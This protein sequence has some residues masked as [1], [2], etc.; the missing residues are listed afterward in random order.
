[1]QIFSQRP[2]SARPFEQALLALLSEGRTFVKTWFRGFLVAAIAFPALSAARAQDNGGCSNATLQGDY[3]FSVLTVATATGPNVVVGL[4]RFDGRGRFQQT[5]FPGNG[6]TD[7]GLTSF[8]TGQTGS[9]TINP[10]CTGFMT[11]DLGSAV[12]TVEN[13]LVI[14]NGGGSIHAVIAK[15]T[16]PGGTLVTPLQ[17]RIEFW[18]VGSGQT[19]ED[20]RRSHRLPGGAA[21]ARGDRRAALGAA[22]AVNAF[23]QDKR[24]K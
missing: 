6:G 13:A 9:Y 10:N 20:R 14:S 15:F 5:D 18:Q 7:L 3:A 24:A 11:I 12:G 17:S 8:R 16:A 2:H 4:G 19:N 1:M 21:Q 23:D 22:I